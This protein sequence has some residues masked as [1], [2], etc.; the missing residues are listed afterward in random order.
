MLVSKAFNI[1]VHPQNTEKPDNDSIDKTRTIYK[2]PYRAPTRTK[3]ESKSL[4]SL[5][6]ILKRK[7][8]LRLPYELGA[9]TREHDKIRASDKGAVPGI[10][11][12]G[13]IKHNIGEV[14]AIE[15]VLLQSHEVTCFGD[16][17][18]KHILVP[19]VLYHWKRRPVPIVI[20]VLSVVA[21]HC[22]CSL[23]GVQ[24]HVCYRHVSHVSA[25]SCR[26]L[27]ADAVSTTRYHH[28][29]NLH[30]KSIPN[31]S[32]W[33]ASPLLPTQRQ[34]QCYPYGPFVPI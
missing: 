18:P 12:Q 13:N 29:V 19:H 11:S 17:L 23:H 28:V 22:K 27:D 8:T 33:T 26:C 7:N 30:L 34:R 14:N 20:W 1:S 9:R 10:S 24:V 21:Q 16:I 31:F 5:L 4:H 2:L 15:R 25:S 32:A 3:P 6:E